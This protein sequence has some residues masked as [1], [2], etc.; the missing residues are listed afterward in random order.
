[1]NN[2]ALGVR[3]HEARKE[4][5]IS[6][7]KLAELCDVGPVHIRKIESGAKLPSISTF[8]LICNALHT[9]P[10]SLLQDSLEP[11]DVTEQLQLMERINSLSK[12]QV[13]MVQRLIDTVLDQK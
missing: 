11:N 6:S 12:V 9:S 8:V 13:A 10:Q 5:G 2:M 7:N 3:I 4:Q 1:M